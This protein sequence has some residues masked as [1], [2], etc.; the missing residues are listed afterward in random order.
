MDREVGHATEA[1]F[2]VRQLMQELECL[3][4]DARVLFVCSYGDYHDT[5][6]ALPVGEVVADL[7]TN[8]LAESAYSQ[9]RVQ[10]IE[11]REPEDEPEEEVD[12]EAF[13]V[14]ILRS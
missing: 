14:V 4:P 5:P 10:L 11:D 2:T 12:E 3:D 9:S 8:D 13:P 1:A 6:Q 7:T